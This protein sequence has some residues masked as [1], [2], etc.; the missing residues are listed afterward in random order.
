MTMAMCC[1]VLL[2]QHRDWEDQNVQ[3]I[4]REAPRAYFFGYGTHPGDRQMSLDGQWKFHWT[5]T[6]DTQPKGFY[7]PTFDD[8]S[9]TTFPVPGDW[10]M[11]GYGTPIYCS[12]GYTFKIDPP[13]VMGEP[14]KT[15]TAFEERNPTAVY[16]RAFDIPR[17]W[18]GMEVYLRFGAVGSAFYVWVN[19]HL[20]GYAQGSMEPAEFRVTDYLNG[21][22]NQI[23]LQVLKY[24]DGSYLE[25]QDMWRLAGIHR[26]VTL[27]ATPKIR[28]RDIGIRTLLDEHY[29]DARIII[30]PELA[31]TGKEQ[32]EG[33]HV[34]ACLTDEEGH[35]VLDSVLTQDA[36]PMLNTDHKAAVM[37]D[38]TPQRGYPKW[39]WLTANIR[40]PHLWTAET[41]YLYTLRLSLTDATGAVVE[42][43]ALKVGFRQVEIKNGQLLV[44]GKPVRLR[45]VNR[46][47]MDPVTGHVMT[48][49]RMLQDIL[50]MKRANINAVRTCHYPNHERWYELCDSIGLYV[51][52]EADIEEHG[53]R[54][55]LAS[56]P[57]WAAAWTDRTQRLVI[58]DRNHPSVVMW[59][60]G[61][62]A[63]WGPNFAFTAAWT[64]EYDPT[65]PVH[66]E[67]AQGSG[68]EAFGKHGDPQAVDVISRF[69]PR[70]QDD[71][72]NPGVA[73]NNMERPENARWERLLTIARDTSDRRP[74]LTSEYAH[75]MGNA[76]GNLSEYW[77]EIYSHPRMLGGF[78]WEWADEGIF[79]QREGKRMVA[80]GG[81]FGDQPNLKA[82]CVKGIVSSDRQPTPKYDE[83]KAVYSPIQFALVDGQVQTVLRDTNVSADDFDIRQTHH[84]GL[85]DVYAT[86]KHDTR[87]AKAGHEVTHQQ[88]VTDPEWYV[89]ALHGKDK[90]KSRRAT[91]TEQLAWA[92][93][94]FSMLRPHL[95]RAP[96]DND[97]GFGNWI[98]KDWKEQGLD[99][100]R[101]SV[102]TPLA[103]E[104]TTGGA[105]RARATMAYL[106]AKGMVRAEY[107]F[108]VLSDRSIDLTVTFTPEGHLPPLPCMGITLVLPKRH[109]R[110]TYFGRGPTDNY[111]DRHTAAAIGLWHSTVAQ[112]YVHYPR[113]QDSGNHDDVAFVELTDNK[114][115]GWRIACT[116]KPFSFSALPYSTAHLYATTHDCDLVE[117]AQFIYLNIDAAVM[118]LG[119]SSC[120]PGVLTKYAIP[121]QPHTLHVRIMEI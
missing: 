7:E 59:S 27:F 109:G 43:V 20:A 103:T 62:E 104:P 48:E 49:E 2:A 76:L 107:D 24:C 23:T 96:T 29:E 14:K 101:D 37:N 1:Q 87:W 93:E 61:N 46:H 55:Q 120:G 68:A 64:H 71:Y 90:K 118:G 66:Y 89:Q 38:R 88:F 98:A 105:V 121:M 42:Q 65:R 10:E 74:V 86:L 31:V 60:L 77:D 78:I 63:G 34:T 17:E 92:H 97:K 52:D 102:I 110:L 91:S 94:F 12:S 36:V 54:G 16:R 33:F 47:E 6:P 22:H 80:Y 13:R 26:S 39:G 53:L 56:D 70:T 116:N 41:P 50:L 3:H 81:D 51:I 11:N 119:N 45:G 44:N 8:S 25:D 113:P 83:V 108:T 32:G 117:D 4:R 115:K 73:D 57:S 18:D 72:L 9:W 30:H 69:Y 28:F 106:T 79:S 95:F 84:D 15:Y 82:F 75:A 58:R 112:Q 67:G 99:Q 114:G 111:P 19:G 5:K 100:L 40:H 35:M 85:L 21:P